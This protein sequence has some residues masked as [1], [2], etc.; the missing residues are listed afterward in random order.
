MYDHWR[1]LLS[2]DVI[3][4][5]DQNMAFIKENTILMSSEELESMIRFPYENI[6]KP[7]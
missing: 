3:A 4:T 5:C 2:E 6:P 7:F 1:K